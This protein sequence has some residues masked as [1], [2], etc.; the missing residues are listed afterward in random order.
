MGNSKKFQWLIIGAGPA[1]IAAVGKL[2]DHKVEKD[3]IA[4]MDTAFKVGDLGEKWYS[5]SSNTTVDLFLKFLND[6]HAFEYKKCKE[7]FK[8]NTLNPKDTCLLKEIAT[9]LQ[10]VTNHL[11]K[12]I[13]TVKDEAISLNLKK[14]FWNVKTQS[15]EISAHNVILCTGSEPKLLSYPDLKVIPLEVALNPSK[16]EKEIQPDDTI[17]VFGAS[18]SAILVLANLLKQ[19]PKMVHNFYRSPHHYALNM[20]E[21]I[22]FDNTGL[23]GFAANWA[24]DHLDGSLPKNLNR[25]HSSDTKFEEILSTCNKVVYPVGFERR[26]TPVLEQFP[27]AKYQETTGIIAPGLFGFGIAYP[28]AQ[29]DPFGNLEYRVGLWKFMDYLNSILPIWLKYSNKS[30]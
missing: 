23:K 2:L 24:K 6:C 4:W 21:W 17:G 28:Q 27:N 19:N 18:H 20:G 7:P 1:G 26:Q 29:F 14:G 10:W 15:T 22:L 12:E 5:V 11:S 13:H 30:S 8:L 9:P 3:Q 16:L 25:C